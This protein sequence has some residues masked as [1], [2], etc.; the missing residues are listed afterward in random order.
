MAQKAGSCNTALGVLLAG[1]RPPSAWEKPVRGRRGARRGGGRRGRGAP[2]PYGIPPVGAGPRVRHPPGVPRPW[3]QVLLGCSRALPSPLCPGPASGGR[4]ARTPTER[5]DRGRAGPAT[6]RM[7]AEMWLE[8]SGRIAQDRRHLRGFSPV[9]LQ[10]VP[11]GGAA[12]PG[13]VQHTRGLRSEAVWPLCQPG[14]RCSRAPPQLSQGG[15]TR[16][17]VAGERVARDHLWAGD[18]ALLDHDASRLGHNAA[19]PPAFLSA[20][21]LS[22]T[23]PPFCSASVDAGSAHHPAAA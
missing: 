21:S 16:E 1:A 22:Y 5:W 2:S 6:V 12:R 7:V 17:R 9:F 14:P 3:R 11:P 10:R 20:A 19:F 8:V 15:C 4:R 13:M 23:Q 18:S